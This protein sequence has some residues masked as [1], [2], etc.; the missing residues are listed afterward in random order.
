MI[1]LYIVG[2][3]GAGKSTLMAELT[4]ECD[5]LSAT[6]PVPHDLLCRPRDDDQNADVAVEIGKRRENFSGTDALGMSIQPKAVAWIK[7][8]PHSLVLG[9][10]ARLGTTGFLMAARNT[11]YRVILVHLGAPDDVLSQRRAQRGSKQNES[12]MQGATT[13]SRRLTERMWLDAEVIGLSSTM[14]PRGVA[15]E[16]LSFV[17]ELEVLM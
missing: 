1:L 9:E 7:T 13:R 5:R 11:G 4:R 16:L 8:R 6:G 15:D 3:P 17:P 14:E 2:P 10:G 12:W